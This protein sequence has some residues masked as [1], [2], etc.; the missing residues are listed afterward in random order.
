M[1]GGVAAI[2]ANCTVRGNPTTKLKVRGFTWLY[3]Q[4]AC[5]FL[6]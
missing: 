5:E 6:L 4:D 1:E 2:M 3:S